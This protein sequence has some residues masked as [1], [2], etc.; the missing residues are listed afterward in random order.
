MKKDEAQQLIKSFIKA[1]KRAKKT[2]EEIDIQN[3]KL[4][5]NECIEKFKFL[6]Y[7]RTTKYRGFTNYDDLNQEGLMALSHAMQNYNP[8]KSSFC[9]WA[10]KYIETKIAR[11]ANAH[12]A[13]RFPMRYA[14]INTPFRET[15]LPIL[16]DTTNCP[17]KLFE[18]SETASA[19]RNVMNFLSKKQKKIIGLYFGFEGSKPMNISKICKKMNMPRMRCLS[20]IDC[21]LEIL[22]NKIKI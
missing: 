10:L 6:V 5:E 3:L 11:S 21:A 17:D 15:K 7:M 16:L 2:K 13:I 14:K 19:V 12:T 1:K 22:K 9:Y 4:I 20:I 8:T 18:G